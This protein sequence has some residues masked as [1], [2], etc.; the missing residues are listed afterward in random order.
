MILRPVYLILIAIT[1]LIPC[2]KCWLYLKHEGW[3]FSHSKTQMCGNASGVHGLRNAYVECICGT[4]SWKT[5]AESFPKACGGVRPPQPWVFALFFCCQKKTSVNYL[6]GTLYWRSSELVSSLFNFRK[7]CHNA[8]NNIA[9][10][11]I[12]PWTCYPKH[13]SSL[14]MFP[15]N[16]ELECS[17]HFIMI[18]QAEGNRGGN[19]SN[20]RG[21]WGSELTAYSSWPYWG[22]RILHIGSVI[23]GSNLK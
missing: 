13:S 12:F 19:N 18:L 1:K 16:C 3:S 7:W 17:S 21:C 8:L 11:F 22:R 2:I 15:I 9:G 23:I 4:H 14:A 20:F 5:P 10:W 6:K